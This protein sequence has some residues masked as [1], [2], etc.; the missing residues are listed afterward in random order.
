MDEYI[1]FFLMQLQISGNMKFPLALLG[2][3]DYVVR[4]IGLLKEVGAMQAHILCLE[5]C[6]VLWGVQNFHPFPH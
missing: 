2:F 4:A 5:T 3:C 1:K 6:H